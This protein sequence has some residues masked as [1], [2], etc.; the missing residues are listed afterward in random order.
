MNKVYQ[1]Y[2]NICSNFFDQTSSESLKQIIQ[3]FSRSAIKFHHRQD[4]VNVRDAMK[5]RKFN[6]QLMLLERAFLDPNG[7]PNYWERK[8]IILSK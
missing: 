5:V 2:S 8:H 3:E 4:M 1:K 6:D 7:I